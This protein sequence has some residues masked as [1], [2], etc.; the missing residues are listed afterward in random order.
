MSILDLM[1]TPA[2]INHIG[3]TAGD[4]Y[5]NAVP[6]IAG[7]DDVLGYLE[8]ISE[9]IHLVNSDTLVTTHQWIQPPG[10][11]LTA[12]DTIVVA[13]V[14]YRCIESLVVSNARTGIPHHIEAKVVQVSG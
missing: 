10:V 7:T 8:P 13:G 6:S 2:T 4:T 5:G 1:T 14:S 11:P 9:A 3:S 12:N